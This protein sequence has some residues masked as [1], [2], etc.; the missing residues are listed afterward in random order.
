MFFDKEISIKDI[1]AQPS[2]FYLVERPNERFNNQDHYFAHEFKKIQ[3]RRNLYGFKSSGQRPEKLIGLALSGGGQRSAAFQLG[4]LS[5]LSKVPFGQG[6]LLNRVDYIS[7]VSGGSWANGAYWASKRSDE[8]LFRCLDDATEHGKEKVEQEACQIPAKMLRTKQ[9]ILPLPIKDGWFKQKKKAWEEAITEI[10]LP[11]GNIEFWNENSDISYNHNFDRKP[12]PIFNSSHSIPVTSQEANDTHFPFQTTPDYLGTIADCK[13]LGI[14]PTA[15]CP[16]GRAGF[17]VRHGAKGFSWSERK[18]QKFWKFWAPEDWAIKGMTLSK[19]LAHS[20]AVIN[21]EILL[22]YDFDLKYQGQYIEEIRKRYE[23]SDGGKTENLGLLSLIERGVD[24][25]IVS[26]MG[27]DDPSRSPFQDFELA[28]KQVKKLLGCEVQMPKHQSEDKNFVFQSSYMIGG[29]D[30][31]I[32][33]VKPMHSNVEEFKDYLKNQKRADGSPQYEDIV[34]FLDNEKC[35]PADR[36]PQT[37]TMQVEYDERL[38]RAY[39]LLGQY[40]AKEHILVN[41]SKLA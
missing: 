13:S 17:F 19:T 31:T 33:H 5:G 18:W 26:Y 30:K 10:Y 23:L 8:E 29:K 32:L 36:F 15:E 38:I 28:S 11:D 22:Q 34:E 1:P 37:P 35:A 14:A 2:D 20:S 16:K 7:S 3:Q 39:Y 6:T 12:Y 21:A 9:E 40:V 41:L 25:I 27:K 4:L 24:F